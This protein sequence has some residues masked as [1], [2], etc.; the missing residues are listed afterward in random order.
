MVQ[1]LAQASY[2][3]LINLWIGFINFI[4]T[5]LGGLVLL[6]L[7]LV[8]GNGLGQLVEKII[9]I[10]K[11]DSALEKTSFKAFLDR[12]GIKLGTG[13]FLG[14]IVSWLVI[15]SFLIA[16]CNIWGLIAVSDFIR[17]VV[18]YLP[19]VIVAVLI[20]LTAIILGEYFAKFVRASVAGAGF[21]YQK[22]LSSLSRWVF[23]VFGILAALSQ[24]N[25][26]PRIIET[27]FTGIVAMIAIAGGLAF[28]FGG[29]D[30]AA[31]ILNKIKE[32]LE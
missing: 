13:Y 30:V 27:L 24:L 16:A 3:A 25:I 1:I 12:A 11:I 28:G 20:L 6:F 5:L 23:Y 15:L 32:E 21:K 26:A 17:S 29:K 8:I 10:I 14:Q 9:N 4:P 22:F 2:E 7:G 18:N 19:N 31:G